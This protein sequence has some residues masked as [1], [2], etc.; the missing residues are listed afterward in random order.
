M[1]N[2]KGMLKAIIGS[3][4]KVG[5]IGFGGG[6][7]LIPIIEKEVVIEKGLIDEETYKGHTITANVTPGALP[8]K[9]AAASGEVLGG[10]VGMF[11]GAYSL[12]LPG[13]FFTIL[14][15]SIM[16]KLSPEFLHY[17]EYA[18]IGVTAFIIALL[19]EYIAKVM[20]TS[21]KEHFG[22]QAIAIM[23]VTAACTFGNE[24]R[25]FI[26]VFASSLPEAFKTSLLD[27]STIDFLLVAF[28]VIS[29]TQGIFNNLRGILVS[30]VS[31]AFLLAT[32]D[33]SP[34]ASNIQS[35]LRILVI[36]AI[37][38]FVVIDGKNE[39]KKSKLCPESIENNS[40]KLNL[41][42]P[43]GQ[44]LL[45]VGAIAVTAVISWALVGDMDGYLP[46][47]L[48]S[49]VTS[50]GGG[51]AYLTVADGMF[52]GSGY[53]PAGDFYGKILP[54]ANA[55]PGPILVKILAGVGYLKGFKLAGM[56]GGYAMSAL[57]MTAGVG[58]SVIVFAFVNEIY[59]SFSQMK[60]FQ[61]LNLWIVP[62]VCG[63]LISTILAM[64]NESFRILQIASINNGKGLGLFAVC[65]GL[66][67]LLQHK[68]HLHDVIA[69]LVAAAL[70]LGA[71]LLIL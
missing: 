68:L 24:I 70:S 16:S 15:L 39:K 44:S 54:I 67:Y 57:G 27:V 10:K 65:F 47:G 46:N 58:A 69:L 41:R 48:V 22:A 14:L 31:V 11:V 36:I 17:V 55:L 7:A 13:T 25:G 52:V 59:Q 21:E 60:V 2:K 26:S 32:G 6:S 71:V 63:L 20:N 64:L 43:L 29:G 5:F 8:V 50:F 66:I 35:G 3:F 23:L 56:A 62:V 18:S 42:R 49:S 33:M 37:V 53:L 40:E 30:I 38:A 34:V 9:L 12:A 4:L 1:A 61:L 45:F 19:I 28:L 51:E